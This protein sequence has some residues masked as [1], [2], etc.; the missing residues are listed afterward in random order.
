MRAALYYWVSTADQSCV[1]QDRDYAAFAERARY[2]VV[3]MSKGAASGVKL[4]RAERRKLIFLIRIAQCAI[5]PADRVTHVIFGVSGS[6]AGGRFGAALL[7]KTVSAQGWADPDR[8]HYEAR[9]PALCHRG[10]G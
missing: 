7:S 1:C 10:R 3:G 4:D 9:G 5:L 2:E 6:S 8:Q